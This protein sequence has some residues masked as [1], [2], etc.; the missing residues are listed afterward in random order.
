M[1]TKRQECS[2]C[3]KKYDG[4]GNNA[5][6][7]NSGRCC[8]RC[9]YKVIVTRLEAMSK[10]SA[11]KKGH[12]TKEE[13]TMLTNM[14]PLLLT[15][16]LNFIERAN[17]KYK[18]EGCILPTLDKLIKDLTEVREEILDTHDCHMGPEDGCQVCG[19]LKINKLE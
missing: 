11:S 1:K 6:S 18:E 5:E 2:I 16:V 12:R 3:G 9:N 8:D 10:D 19:A 7:V 15:I 17:K 14:D 13:I 4:H